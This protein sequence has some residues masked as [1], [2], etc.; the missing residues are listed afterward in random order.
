[1]QAVLIAANIT[2]SL[3][4]LI[5]ASWSDYKTREVSDRVWLLFAPTALLLSIAELLLYEPSRLPLFGL[6]FAVTVVIA[7]ALNYSGG[8]GGADSK[9]LMCLGLALPFSPTALVTP[10]LAAGVSPLSQ[11]IFPFTVLSNSVLVAAFSAVAMIFHNLFRRVKTR[12]KMFEATLANEPAWKK[13]LVLMTGCKFSIAKLKAIW[14]IF[15]LEDIAE[16]NGEGA[17]KRKLLVWPKDEKRDDIVARLS[18]AV[19]AGKI[20]ADVWATPGLP[21]LIFVTIGLIIALFFGDIIWLLISL[22]L[23]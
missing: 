15:P 14:H 12:Q 9:A 7:V 10:V 3:A 6:S 18:K 21:M 16:E 5:Y 4:C 11:N 22:A 19:D 13:V 1:M 20:G 2:L 23:G 8:F 17:A